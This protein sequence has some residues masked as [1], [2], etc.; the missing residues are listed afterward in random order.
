MAPLW[1]VPGHHMVRGIS[2]SG[3]L[4]VRTVS[5]NGTK[6]ERRIAELEEASERMKEGKLQDLPQGVAVKICMGQHKSE[7]LVCIL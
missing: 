6:G 1:P 3:A 7:G 5:C 4:F 2:P